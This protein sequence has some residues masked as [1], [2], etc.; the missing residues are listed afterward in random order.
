VD[1]AGQALL[2]RLGGDGARL[3]AIGIYTSYIL[4]TINLARTR[5]EAITKGGKRPDRPGRERR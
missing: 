5:A 2:R 4:Q 1:E 3:H